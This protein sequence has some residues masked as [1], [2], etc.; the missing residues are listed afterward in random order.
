MVQVQLVK[1]TH[2]RHRTLKEASLGVEGP[3]LF[4]A[5]P[6]YLRNIDCTQDKFKLYLD[7]LLDMI[8]D[9]PNGDKFEKPLAMDLGC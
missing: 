9:Q 1:G 2:L 5:L 3:L 4:N 8:P 7:Q 6:I